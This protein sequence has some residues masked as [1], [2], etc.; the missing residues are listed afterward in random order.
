[1]TG[2]EIRDIKHLKGDTFTT[3]FIKWFDAEWQR[4]T[5]MVRE[6]GADLSIPIVKK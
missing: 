6:S 4:I 3:Q 5:Q 1:M 2:R